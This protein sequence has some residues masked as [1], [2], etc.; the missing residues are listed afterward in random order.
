MITINKPIIS[1]II[2]T[3]NRAHLIGR[4]IRSVLNQTFSH[5]ELIVVDDGSTDNTEE[6]VKSFR[7]SRISFIR[8]ERNRGV[9]AARNTGIN[10]AQGEYIAF[11][12]SDDEWLPTKLER[13]MALFNRDERG[14]LGL[15]L[16]EVLAPGPHGE[17]RIVPQIQ[18]MTYE[19]LLLHPGNVGYFMTQYLIK[20][21]LTTA[22][23]YFDEDL[24]ASEEWDILLRLTRLCRIDY[25]P[26][27]LARIYAGSVNR[28]T[29]PKNNLKSRLKILEK[30]GT[31]LKARPKVLRSC[32]FDLAIRNYEAREAMSY[33]RRYLK[34]AIVVYPWHPTAYIGLAFSVFGKQGFGLFL[35]MRW[36]LIR[37]TENDL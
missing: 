2:P 16:C 20:R 19:N 4:A 1:V 35:K 23:L 34:A 6:V 3:Y 33:I 27:V 25:V 15:V 37:K 17:H 5:Y 11:N 7:D 26:E 14:D 30:Y 29:N 9:S 32:Y 22:E 18:L 31:E 24:P 21:N 36:S 10:A 12:D 13:Q 8:H 28:I